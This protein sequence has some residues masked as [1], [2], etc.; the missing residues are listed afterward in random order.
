MVLQRV[1]A[2]SLPSSWQGLKDRLPQ[3]GDVTYIFFIVDNDTATGKPWC[4]DVRAALPVVEK[5]FAQRSHLDVSVV[6][7]GS[8]AAYVT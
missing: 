5:Y 2:S 7:V 3:P 8:R 4:P 6:S 1:S